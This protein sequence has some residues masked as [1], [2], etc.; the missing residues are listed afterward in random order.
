[1]K[2]AFAGT[3]SPRPMDARTDGALSEVQLPSATSVEVIF[4]RYVEADPLCCPSRLTTV[5]Y[6][7][8]RR[9]KGFVIAPV[10]AQSKPTAP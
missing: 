2:G 1:M 10:S 3:L 7:I 5:R 4:L 9:A 8:E 6:R